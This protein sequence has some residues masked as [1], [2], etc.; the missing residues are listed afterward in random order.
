MFSFRGDNMGKRLGVFLLLL[1]LT[2]IF[3][4][5]GVFAA[6]S[7][8]Y[9]NQNGDILTTEGVTVTPVTAGTTVLSTGWYVV[10]SDV[11]CTATITVSESVNLILMDGCTLSV[12]GSNDNAGINVLPGNSLTIYGQAAGTG[13]LSTQGGTNSAG[14][15]GRKNSSSGTVTINS[16]TVI[17]TGGPYGSGIGGGYFGNNG[18]VNIAGGTVTATAGP[19]GTV[20]T[21]GYVLY[22]GAGIGGGFMG[23]GGAI[24]ISGGTI[25]AT[26]GPTNTAAGAGIGGGAGK[27]AGRITISG[28]T[29]TARST[30]NGSGIGGGSY[31]SGGII[32]I[33]GGNITASSLYRGAGIGG[34][35]MKD[36]GSITITGGTVN[37]YSEYGGTGIGGGYL[38]TGGTIYIQGGDITSTGGI[39]GAGIGSGGYYNGGNITI[40]GGV[41]R[42]NGGEFAAG[43]GSGG[44]NSAS[45]HTGGTVKILGGKVFAKGYYSSTWA[46]DCGL[47]IGHGRNGVN[48]TVLIDDAAQVTLMA[49]GV[50][51][52]VTTKGTC[53][54]QGPAAGSLL[55]AYEDGVKIAGTLI[56]LGNSALASGTGYTISGNTV[57]LT[58]SGSSYVI[59][60]DTISRNIVAS[61]GKTAN[62]CLF[63]TNI[64]PASG[65][66]FN[67]TGA[68]VNMRLVSDNALTSRS[69]YAGL[70]APAGA[71]L[72]V[73]GTGSLSATGGTDAA[74]IGGGNGASAGSF[75]FTGGTVNAFGSGGG[76][77]IG[78]GS[79][80]SGGSVSVTGADTLVSTTGGLT[81]YDI[82]SG[83][84]NTTGGT[85]SVNHNAVVR[86]NRNG[87]NAN[88][89]YITCLIDGDGAGLAA[90]TYLDSQKQLSF[91]DSDIT[92]ESGAD[93]FDTV[94]LRVDL[95]GLSAVLPE[96]YVSFEAN[97]VE[98]GQSTVTRT[99]AG[100]STGTAGVDFTP[101]AGNYTLSARYVQST[102]SDS[103]YTTGSTSLS[104]AYLVSKIGQTSLSVGVPGITTYGDGAFSLL[105]SGGSGSGSL[106]Y[107]VTSGDAVSVNSEGLITPEKA[108]TA[109]VTV[110]KAGDANY[111]EETGT[112]EIT[113][114]KAVPDE[115]VFPSSGSLTYGASLS[116]SLLS[117]GSGDG[118]FAWENPDTVPTVTN[119]GYDVV[120]TPRDSDN[121]DYSGLTLIQTV[122]I[123]V[124]KA[125]PDVTFPTAQSVTYGSALAD[126]V[127]SGGS[128]DGSFAWEY[129]DIV[130]TVI[131]SGYN[132]VFTPLD[133]DNY[134]TVEQIVSII[135]TKAEQAPLSVSGIPDELTYGDTAFSL[136]ISG[137][138]G[139]GSLSYEVTSGDAV[140]VN[141]EGLIT[142]EKAGTATVTVTKAGDANYEEETGTIEITVRKAVPDEV[143]FPSS[144][145]LTYGASLSDSLLSGG[146]G[147]GSF[148]WENPDTVP[149][150][151]NSGY[152]VVFTPRDSDN[153]DYS[154]LTLIQTVA[155]TVSKAT[156]D[157]TF[158]TAQSVTYGSALADS[159]LSGGSGDGSFAWEYPDIV[160]TVINS[161]YTVVFTPDDTDNYLPVENTVAVIV[162]QADQMPLTLSGIPENLRYGHAAFN[163]TC[164]GGSGTGML[165]YEVTSGNAVTV[166]PNG[167][168]VVMKPGIVT[169]A[170]TKAAD[171]NYFAR[172]DSVQIIVKKANQLS[173]SVIG[174]PEEIADGNP[175]FNI[176]VVGGNGT[177]T[178]SYVLTSGDSINVDQ[179]GKISVLQPG[180]SVLTVTKAGDA[181]YLPISASVEIHVKNKPV[182]D[183]SGDSKITPTPTPVPSVT[184]DTTE[185]TTPDATSPSIILSP[186]DVEE[187]SKT[188]AISIE[189]RIAD[190]PDN[191][192]AIQ[193]ENGAIIEIDRTRET[194]RIEVQKDDLNDLGE[195]EALVVSQDKSVTSL[196]IPVNEAK[197]P[198]GNPFIFLWIA[199]GLAGL[200]VVI[201]VI[202]REIR[203][204]R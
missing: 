8:S 185:A 78:G 180:T 158:P 186:S 109:T 44:H 98:I 72:T 93:A 82:G 117:G 21:D 73:S 46:P 105:I 54:I 16:G 204:R 179:T 160:P 202:V 135:V 163:L 22:T 136:L 12:T 161:G 182:T 79:G 108:G 147:D 19:G 70:Q 64:Q 42:A 123:T 62:V 128:G 201:V 170:V 40:S 200:G 111:E 36:G 7:Y 90:G 174:I 119:S 155:I 37:A 31:G 81:G 3:I 116:D 125:T 199:L 104:S 86:L 99:A 168:I 66:A 124:S 191:A 190:L 137:G 80:R 87:T 38:A 49:S 106:S 2:L 156:P 107:E 85:L 167:R 23:T 92:P 47:D 100:S 178:L 24:N 75:S 115:V 146:S 45:S 130:P 110:T 175:G 10:E 142:P 159:V 55:G 145:S 76:A 51:S 131:N 134:F 151:T 63:D 144:G 148:A 194:I 193:L 34:G 11:T 173:L 96:G 172:Q 126:S 91:I 18:T 198:A 102:I 166:D 28:G 169:L 153:Y 65:C 71:V 139:S 164:S 152:D 32:L 53:I 1:G 84:G 133:T 183:D 26:S 176:A 60:G 192:A 13:T 61:S 132:V 140:S 189:V 35:D 127:L 103:Y 112:I 171:S 187:D 9:V 58:G 121:Y 118:S 88:A 141:S 50:D 39:W 196:K 20:T 17:S 33:S 122:A 162:N 197:S 59:F 129:P 101:S 154:G 25:T 143:V 30:Q 188:G 67:M 138:S 94:S 77:G 97:G 4:P 114:R 69:G 15:G 83:D 157:V 181:Y 6:D 27:D 165:Q 149:T 56:D 14:I 120:F 43:I 74:G 48:G 41:V 113:V 52:S 184:P 150:V 195:L 203:K 5:L 177:G 68:T 57:T 89:S 95:D 29:V